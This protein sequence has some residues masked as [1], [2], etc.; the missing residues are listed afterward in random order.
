[1]S[2]NGGFHERRTL[3]TQMRQAITALRQEYGCRIFII[4]LGDLRA[5]NEPGRVR[6]WAATLDELARE[7]D[8][9]IFVSTGNRMPR[10]GMGVEQGIT[11]YPGYLLEPANRLC[12]P[13]GAANI[14]AVGA[15]ANGTGVRPITGA[16]EPSPFSRVGPGAGGIRKPDFVD[17][18]DTMV[19]DAP[20]ASLP[21]APRVPEAGVI[22]LSHDFLRQLIT[23][24]SGASFAAP[25]LANKAA[26]LLR[27][28]PA[29]SANLIRALLA[30]AATVPEE[31][32]MRLRG[33]SAAT[34]S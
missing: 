1:M 27:L 31:C 17:V 22:T 28:F 33:A 15:F 3:P 11:H 16:L 13:A 21:W 19:F 26:G 29:A 32:E 14:V 20:S 34:V 25:L 12:E 10:S 8:V 6:P 7:L 23:S 24:G 30:G 5:R 9:L 2:D 4:S 18:G